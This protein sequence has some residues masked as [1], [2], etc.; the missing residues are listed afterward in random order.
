MKRL[1]ILLIFIFA[2]NILNAQIIENNENNHLKKFSIYLGAGIRNVTENKYEEVYGEN[3][4]S[5]SAD[6]G[7][8]IYRSLEL[9]LH[10]D[11]FKADGELTFSK[12]NTTLKIIPVELGI[13]FILGNNIIR[14]YVGAGMGYYIYKEE[15]YIGTI[16][17]NKIGFLA[18]GGIRFFVI[19]PLFIDLKLKYI[20]LNVKNDENS[21]IQLGGISYMG[22]I[23]I[24]F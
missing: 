8:K 17:K 24:S 13:R 19:K 9:F 2:S 15:N 6:I 22:G 1:S 7:L 10:T 12:E 11:Y 16:D 18:E 21:N 14:P 23:G 20:S 4:I 3:N 5:F